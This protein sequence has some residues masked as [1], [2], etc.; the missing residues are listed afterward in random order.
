MDHPLERVLSVAGL[1]LS[2]KHGAVV[3]NFVL[4]LHTQAS[5]FWI[6]HIIKVGTTD[7]SSD[8]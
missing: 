1:M 3:V 6:V 2:P 8:A 7:M 4:Y 5:V